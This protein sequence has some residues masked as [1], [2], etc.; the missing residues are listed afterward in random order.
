MFE[1]HFIQ[2]AGLSHLGK[3]VLHE[4]CARTTYLRYLGHAPTQ[5]IEIPLIPTDG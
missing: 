4:L 5:H 2:Q 3:I 1:A